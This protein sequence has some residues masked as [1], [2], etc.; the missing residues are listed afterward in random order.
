LILQY[1]GS[2]IARLC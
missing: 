2:L 1:D